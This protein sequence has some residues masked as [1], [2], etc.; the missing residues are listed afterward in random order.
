MMTLFLRTAN[1]HD[2][3]KLQDKDDN[4]SQRRRVS[5]KQREGRSRSQ[6]R[7]DE[8]KAEGREKPDGETDMNPSMAQ[9]GNITNA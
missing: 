4:D 9:R 6:K 1:R 3:Q 8:E 5:D 7:S 2:K